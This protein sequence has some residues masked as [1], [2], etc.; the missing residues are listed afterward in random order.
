MIGAFF[1]VTDFVGAM[2]RTGSGAGAGA[3]TTATVGVDDAMSAVVEAT[4]AASG[5]IATSLAL[6]AA[7]TEDFI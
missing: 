6:A 2:A 1:V 3:G 5:A 4:I 7:C